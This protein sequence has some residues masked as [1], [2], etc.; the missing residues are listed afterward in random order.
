MRSV[1]D[2]TGL[3]LM[4]GMVL[5]ACDSAVEVQCVGRFLPSLVIVVRDINTGAPA[6]TNARVVAIH[7]DR[8]VFFHLPGSP[9]DTTV[10]AEYHSD[11][12]SLGEFDVFVAKSGYEQW[13]RLGVKVE[14]S[15]PPCVAP[16]TVSLTAYLRPR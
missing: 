16:K 2:V 14:G 9:T 15:K 13:I 5:A 3:A 7:E 4:A 8:A 1:L 12:G 11:S 10:A 6:W